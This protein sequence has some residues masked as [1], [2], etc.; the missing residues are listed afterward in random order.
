MALGI[1]GVL[2]LQALPNE[3]LRPEALG[4]WSGVQ[5]LEMVFL[6]QRG[7][8]RGVMPRAWTAGLPWL[9]ACGGQGRLRRRGHSFMFVKLPLDEG[10]S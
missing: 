3:V 4:N 1:S 10:A 7:A 6:P 8:T 5:E 9:S 2:C